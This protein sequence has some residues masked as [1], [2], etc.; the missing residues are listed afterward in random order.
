MV[1]CMHVEDQC[2]FCI[3]TGATYSPPCG[4]LPCGNDSSLSPWAQKMA[5]PYVA[6]GTPKGS[7]AA[8]A[9]ADEPG[10]Y[11][12]HSA[13]NITDPT[14][15]AAWQAFLQSDSGLKPSDFGAS[16]WAEVKLSAGRAAGGTPSSTLQERRRYVWS[17]R[18]SIELAVT[19]FA[20]ATRALE[21]A[22]GAPGMG[23]YS[24][25]NNFA[26][27]YFCPGP[28]WNNPSK[29]DPNA[30]M[31][32]FDFFEYARARASTL[33]WTEDW[34]GDASAQE[35][36][37]L[38][39]K[40]RSATYAAPP[41][42]NVRYGGYIVPRSGGQLAE[43]AVLKAISL[44]GGGAKSMKYFVFGPEYNFPGNCYSESLVGNP[45]LLQGMAK[46][47]TLIADAEPLLWPAE[48]VRAQVALLMPNA[49]EVWDETGVPL[50]EAIKDAT[51]TNPLT[52]TV[53]YYAELAGLYSALAIGVNVP[54][55]FVDEKMAAA[56]G[57]ALSAYKVIVVTEPNL[58]ANAVAGLMAWARAGGTLV[59]VSN[60]GHADE[61]NE[62]STLLSEALG[63]V[64]TPRAPV[65]VSGA[66]LPVLTN[67]SVPLPST[68]MSAP[69]GTTV[70]IPV[71]GGISTITSVKSGGTVL[72]HFA[73]GQPAI[74]HTSLGAGAGYYM[75][76]L[77]GVS[78]AFAGFAS[79]N[80][81][82]A[83]PVSRLLRNLTHAAGA[84]P[85]VVTSAPEA[86]ALAGT[87]VETPLLVGPTGSVVT[88][89]NWRGA[90]VT[91]P[92]LVNASV[93]FPPSK[94]ES[95]AL[96]KTLKFTTTATHGVVSVEVPALVSADF[97]SIH[98]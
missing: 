73:S 72:G 23:I 40:L 43:G 68:N 54:V 66:A 11:W 78:H 85:S 19:H 94:V 9:L 91:S 33:L 45:D 27:R 30:A 55:D 39:S 8:F 42:S 60:A 93:G 83:G 74:V 3:F 61:Y 38:G 52:N 21:A 41:N 97:L 49:A 80:A 24:N 25:F 63:V 51:I 18:F 10:W 65:L 75:A 7:V 69:N 47:H 76:F 16:T 31:F 77:P 2:T 14:I 50:P 86:T 4:N 34:F 82:A 64:V 53:D 37:F 56:G 12:P 13:P 71:R 89:L 59:A 36:S 15:N 17:M 28:I 98:K 62:A 32:T 35:W 58:P 6:S 44:V 88:L 84:A 70:T 5:G 67:I 22:F 92:F 90:P 1:H 81:S 96:G 48:R 87:C 26:G 46:A 29:T 57:K 95:A 20:K 79:C